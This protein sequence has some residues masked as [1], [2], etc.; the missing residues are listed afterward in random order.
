MIDEV[1]EEEAC[2]P[3]KWLNDWRTEVLVGG[4]DNTLT[5]KR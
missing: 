2:H 1:G 3:K 5:Q 4:Q